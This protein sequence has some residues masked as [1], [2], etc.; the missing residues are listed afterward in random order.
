MAFVMRRNSSRFLLSVSFFTFTL[1]NSIVQSSFAATSTGG[2]LSVSQTRG[3]GS[4]LFKTA[5]MVLVPAGVFCVSHPQ[6]GRNRVSFQKCQSNV[7]D[8]R[9]E[10]VAP[11][12][13]WCSVGNDDMSA[14]YDDRG[15]PEWVACKNKSLDCWQARAD[16]Q[17][18]LKRNILREIN[19][20]NA[21]SPVL[22]GLLG[23]RC[24]KEKTLEGQAHLLSDQMSRNAVYVP[25]SAGSSWYFELNDDFNVNLMGNYRAR[26]AR[27]ATNQETLGQSYRFRANLWR[28]V[29]KLAQVATFA[30]V[31]FR[32]ALFC[33]FSTKASAG[34][35]AIT[36]GV[37]T[38]GLN[39][40]ERASSPE[41]RK[42][43][44]SVSWQEE[45]ELA[46]RR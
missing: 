8:L 29:S 46:R 3:S 16:L 20:N 27:E 21:A 39:A 44:R 36:G 22:Q 24:P 17:L 7:R 6:A 11:S 1:A 9:A 19:S 13:A 5:A 23:V 10:V 14:A 26:A 31:G 15:T 37:G 33:G 25:R 30:V 2:T 28:G 43:G 12:F 40:W 38:F 42:A 35:G 45:D 41:L 34:V 18:A 32:A 4:E